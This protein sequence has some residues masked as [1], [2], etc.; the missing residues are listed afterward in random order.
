L[1]YGDIYNEQL[2]KIK[3]KL[4]ASFNNNSNH[5]NINHDYFLKT[6]DIPGSLIYREHNDLKTELN[7]LTANIYQIGYVDYTQAIT[8]SL[9]DLAFG[10]T[11]YYELRTVRQLGYIVRA[12]R[13]NNNNVLYYRILVQG[14]VKNP[15]DMNIEIN[16][17]IEKL[18][19]DV[20][21]LKEITFNTYKTSLENE[22]LKE[23]D[24]LSARFDDIFYE[25]SSNT[26]DFGRKF[27]LIKAMS[28]I[29]LADVLKK[30][31]E[32]FIENPKVLSLQLFSN[33]EAK[34]TNDTAYFKNTK[35]KYSLNKKITSNV[36]KNVN[37]MEGFSFVN[38]TY[39][40]GKRYLKYKNG[41][42]NNKK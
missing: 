3:D 7:H 8:T 10:N 13:V 18:H 14:S 24:N 38:R 33:T 9:M 27:S 22:L 4:V 11:F 15:P 2:N 26:L 42:M 40:K 12:M 39:L 6:Y 17:V 32:I 41:F 31:E 5:K 23:K 37:L 29:T 1:F 21:N 34:N 36:Y 19:E 35:E 30:F 20:K 28:N 16:H 25:I